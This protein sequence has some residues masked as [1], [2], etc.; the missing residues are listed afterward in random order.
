MIKLGDFTDAVW[1]MTGR[2]DVPISPY[3]ASTLATICRSGNYPEDLITIAVNVNLNDFN[4]L[5]G[6]S[7]GRLSGGA[8]AVV[9]APMP[10]G[11]SSRR[12]LT[13]DL[14]F[15]DGNTYETI[16]YVVLDSIPTENL[17]EMLRKCNNKASIYYAAGEASIILPPHEWGRLSNLGSDFHVGLT[18]TALT[19]N[20]S[21]GWN[22]AGGKGATGT[23]GDSWGSGMVE[24]PSPVGHRNFIWQLESCIDLV[25][26]GT[27]AG[28][29][30]F[31]GQEREGALMY[32]EF[33][34]SL[35]R[36]AADR[37]DLLA[38]L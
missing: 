20:E 34:I 11:L 21:R 8:S 22:W 27:S 26:L 4:E 33:L 3:L 6:Q 9:S 7:Y 37:A 23:T 15:T 35:R 19:S 28:I 16:D 14:A 30:R 31:A 38:T 17:A 10:E 12:L 5:S 32:Q 1:G 29:L 36:Y 18:I 13:S 25:T 24:F 2:P